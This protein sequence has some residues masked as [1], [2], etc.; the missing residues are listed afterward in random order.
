MFN[1]FFS[2]DEYA[3]RAYEANLAAQAGYETEAQLIRRQ[4]IDLSPLFAKV[5]SAI[6]NL[7]TPSR[8]LPAALAYDASQIADAGY[9]PEAEPVEPSAGLFEI[10]TIWLH[11]PVAKAPRL[12][13]TVTP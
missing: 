4:S 1:S 2:H 7:F 12:A 13:N 8:D 6:A 5:T 11:R 9:L 10:V 3:A